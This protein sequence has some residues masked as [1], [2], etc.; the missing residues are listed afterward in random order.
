MPP[1]PGVVFGLDGTTYT[2]GPQGTVSVTMEHDRT[3]HT[4]AVV[5][6]SVDIGTH[7]YAFY[8][9]TGQ[10]RP[11]EAYR[12]AVTAL[13][14]RTDHTIDASFAA[15]CRVAFSYADQNGRA[16]ASASL[17]S[18]QVQSQT[19]QDYT[20]PLTGATWLPCT[21]PTLM[22]VGPRSQP[23]T[24]RLKAL[25]TEGANIANDGQEAFTPLRDA[26]PILTGYYFDLRVQVQDAF[27]GGPAGR[28]VMLRLPD[29]RMAAARL[30]AAG[31]ASFGH[32][33]RASYSVTSTG[34]GVAM[35]KT[36][37]L[38]QESTVAVRMISDDDLG[39]GALCLLLFLLAPFMP[40]A[41][42]AVR[43]RRGARG[44]PQG[45]GAPDGGAADTG[46]EPQP[47]APPSAAPAVTE[48]RS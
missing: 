15:E 1:L 11:D 36:I 17:S 10:R 37:R 5:S 39:L 30:D 19:G 31:R 18:A 20:L 14:W 27:L 9:W 38:S 42:R 12:P 6:T 33:P 47:A 26:H 46:P 4:L 2:T 43:R 35:A 25:V 32:L 22:P 16:I 8:R 28:S 45:G 34:G 48:P 41:V 21:A 24:Y 3:A 13:P 23:I 40:A 44:R 7:R 29:G